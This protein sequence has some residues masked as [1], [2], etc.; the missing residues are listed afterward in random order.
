MCS[1]RNSLVFLLGLCIFHWTTQHPLCFLTL[2][3]FYV[4]ART[5]KPRNRSQFLLLCSSQYPRSPFRRTLSREIT[6]G[7]F[8]WALGLSLC[9]VVRNFCLLKCLTLVF[10][11]FLSPPSTSD[12]GLGCPVCSC[13]SSLE[14]TK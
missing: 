2:T 3:S 10:H 7:Q 1:S 8:S 5:Q 9:H 11:D 4:A 6:G 14:L 13:L 12:A